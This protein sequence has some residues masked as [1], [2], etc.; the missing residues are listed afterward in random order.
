MQDNFDINYFSKLFNVSEKLVVIRFSQIIHDAYNNY[1]EYKIKLKN[2]KKYK[3]DLFSEL[4]K[5]NETINTL[6]C[7][8]YTKDSHKRLENQKIEIKKLINETIKLIKNLEKEYNPIL[9][10][11]DNQGKYEYQN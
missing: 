8:V 7:L 3:K 9:N 10:I 1:L 5:C 6:L 11:L 4:D 2:L